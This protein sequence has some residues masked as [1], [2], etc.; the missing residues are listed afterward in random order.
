MPL[1]CHLSSLFQSICA[2]SLF[3]SHQE[4]TIRIRATVFHVLTHHESKVAQGSNVL[5][6]EGQVLFGSQAALKDGTAA[7]LHAPWTATGTPHRK[8]V[9]KWRPHTVI[10]NADGLRVGK[11]S[12]HQSFTFRTTRPWLT[13]LTHLQSIAKNQRLINPLLKRRRC[14]PSANINTNFPVDIR[15]Y[16]NTSICK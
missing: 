9:W 12:R 5:L 16:S 14:P 7:N 10:P 2:H 8:S 4:S 6:K 11:S 13:H 15:G 1:D 3:S